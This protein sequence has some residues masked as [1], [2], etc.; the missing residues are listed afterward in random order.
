MTYLKNSGKDVRRS[1]L[2]TF[3]FWVY[4]TGWH[5]ALP[6]VYLR[7]WWRGRKESGYRRHLL[8]RIGI[9]PRRFVNGRPIWIHAVSVGETRAA[10]PL[11]EKLLE[12]GRKVLLTHMT[13]TGRKAGAEIFK[14]AIADGQ[15]I[16]AYLP[17]DFCWPV[18][19]FYRYFKPEVGMLMETE[20]WPTLVFFAQDRRLP[21]FL[22]NGRL[23][24]RSF[25]RVKK[26]GDLGSALFRSFYQI[27]AQTKGDQERYESLGVSKVVVTGNLKFDVPMNAALIERGMKWKSQLLPRA[28]V[29]AASTREGEEELILKAWAKV[30]KANRPL[31]IIVPRHPQRFDDVAKLVQSHGFSLGRR[32]QLSLEQVVQVSQD[33]QVDVML[34]DSMGEMP[35]YYAASDLVV[36]GGSLLPLGGQN[37]IEPCSVGRPVILGQHTFNFHQASLDALAMGAAWRLATVDDRDVL[38]DELA[39]LINQLLNNPTAVALASKAAAEFSKH[40]QGAADRTLY[41]IAKVVS[42]HV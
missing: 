28:V 1:F 41:E 24:D 37:L 17:Y 18:A 6:F 29:C 42:S 25:R 30:Q 36:M 7:L 40:Y 20:A 11:V 19:S 27:L 35:F 8:E 33:S 15:L 10:I 12:Q 31:L 32:S 38:S 21:L 39:E 14:T 5:L 4:Q 2:L 16:Q 9:Y 13:P 23:S 26:F 34:G 22:I 3:V